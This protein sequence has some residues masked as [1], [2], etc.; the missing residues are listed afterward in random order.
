MFVAIL[1]LFSQRKL[2][3]KSA[4]LTARAGRAEDRR[5]AR[6][7]RGRLTSLLDRIGDG[8]LDLAELQI[9]GM[10]YTKISLVFGCIG[11]DLCKK[12]RVFQHFPKST[13]LSS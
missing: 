9:F 3:S 6:V 5:V 10:F 13:R 11:T 8:V 2:H 12:I 4:L 7:A 1:N